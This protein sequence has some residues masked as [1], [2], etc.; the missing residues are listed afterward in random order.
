MEDD[1]DAFNPEAI[2]Q[3]MRAQAVRTKGP[4]KKVR[5]LMSIT[6]KTSYIM[7]EFAG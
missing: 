7:D 1:E 6:R 2:I 4:A 5:L 3:Q